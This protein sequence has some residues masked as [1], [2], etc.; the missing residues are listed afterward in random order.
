MAGPIRRDVLKLSEL[1]ETALVR[2]SPG[3]SSE[4]SVWRVGLSSAFRVPRLS[5]SR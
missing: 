1:R 3:T 4:T 5:A 2:S